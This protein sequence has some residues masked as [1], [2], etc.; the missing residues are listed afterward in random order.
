MKQWFAVIF[1]F[2]RNLLRG[3]RRLS[4]LCS[5]HFCLSMLVDSAAA[6]AAATF[7]SLRSAADFEL[8]VSTLH[9]LLM[10]G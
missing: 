9:R 5:L 7:N 10:N 1:F 3:P 8:I 6:A 4:E 2:L